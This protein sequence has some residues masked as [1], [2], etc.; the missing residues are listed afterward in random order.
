MKNQK[1]IELDY[2][3]LYGFKI[4]DMSTKAEL[5]S[6]DGQTQKSAQRLLGSKIGEKT[7]EKVM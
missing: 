6:R 2:A 3:R 1:N 7:G 5:A 4:L